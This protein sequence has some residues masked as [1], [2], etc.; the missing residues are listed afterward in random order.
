MVNAVPPDVPM[1]FI[2]RQKGADFYDFHRF[3]TIRQKHAFIGD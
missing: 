3:N 2:G 1:E